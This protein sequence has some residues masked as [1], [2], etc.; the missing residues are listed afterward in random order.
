MSNHNDPVE[1]RRATHQVVVRALIAR[2]RFGLA[3][4]VLAVLMTAWPAIRG[5]WDRFVLSGFASSRNDSVSADTEFF[6]PMDPGVHSAWPAICPICNM[7]LITRKKTDA[8]ILPEGVLARMQLSP[9]RVQLAGVRTETLQTDAND[10]QKLLVPASAVV[11][12]ESGT[13]VYVETMPGMYDALPVK[14]GPKQADHYELLAGL[15]PDQKVVS[16]G[17]FLIDAETRL[18]PSLAVQYFGANQHQ[19]RSVAPELAERRSP[20]VPNVLSQADQAIVTK[21]RICPVTKAPL[22]S[23]GQPVFV[24]VDGIKVAICCQGCETALLKDK[25]KYLAVLKTAEAAESTAP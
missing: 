15:E 22:G 1:T 6:C 14:L 12:R 5:M 25:A 13:I 4:A 21:Q 11:H 18:N 16:T 9:Y 8:V 24:M 10:P 2:L 19:A 17:A 7:D 3:I 20:K 23:M